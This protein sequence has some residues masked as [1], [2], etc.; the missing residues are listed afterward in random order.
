KIR[1]LEMVVGD[2]G[3][4]LNCTLHPA[5]RI[6][7]LGGAIGSLNKRGKRY[8]LYATDEPLHTPDKESLYGSHPFVIIDGQRT[9]GLLIDFPGKIVFDA[10]FT[11]RDQLEIT[12]AGS[13]FD[14]YI[15]DAADKLAIIHEYLELT[16]APFVPPKWAFGFQQSRWSYPDET[17][18]HDVAGRFRANDLPCDAIYMDIDYMDHYKVFEIDRRRFP[19][20]ARFAGE[21][22]AMGFK[23]MPIV[24]PGVKIEKGYRIYEEGRRG[25]Y[26]CLDEHGRDFVAACWPGVVHF[27]DFL[28]PEVRRWWGEQYLPLIEQGI[29]GFWNDMNEPSIFY[30]PDAL[31]KVLL[32]A[33]QYKDFNAYGWEFGSI[34]ERLMGLLNNPEYYQH[35]YQTR[36]DGAHVLHHEIHNLYG[37]DMTRA[38]ADALRE[39]FTDRR[40]LLLSRS[41]YTGLHRF[42]AVWTGDN[43]SWW[44][45]LLV[46]MR[47]VMSYNLAGYLYVGADVGGFNGNVSPELLIR[48]MQLGAFTPLYRNHSAL[49]TRQQEPWEFDEADL[50]IMR[51]VLKLRYALLP[52]AYAEF[53]HAAAQMRPFI[54]PLAFLYAT[55]EARDVEDQFMYGR[56]LMVAPVHQPGRMGRPVHLPEGRWLLWKARRHDE[57]EMRVMGAGDHYVAAAIDEIPLFMKENALVTLGRP[58]NYVGEH[59]NTELIVVGLV[60]GEAEFV[61]YEDD[62]ASNAYREGAYSTLTIRV[63][64]A[65]GDY[66]YELEAAEDPRYP[67]K[68]RRLAFEIY[69]ETGTLHRHAIDVRKGL[70]SQ[71]GRPAITRQSRYHGD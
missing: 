60:T 29:A 11:H 42:A 24:D 49:G 51:D 53:M 57:R 2:G 65:G 55:D 33:A 48:W 7:G 8:V 47:T 62:G 64:R 61:H 10:G 52:Y 27:P 26:F 32:A 41:S 4:R 36:L 22:K 44:D 23:L 50:T 25:G 15:F 18:I 31:H 40:F 39:H 38:T 59:E 16:G 43:D 21:M 34:R 28:R 70:G 45:H 9:F 63:G 3:V 6:W 17:T 1:H 54:L 30:T 46:H 12:V 58:M 35:F 56:S 66:V 71:S 37:F 68:V 20:F 5:D 19:D 14:L 67:L 13:D 69:D